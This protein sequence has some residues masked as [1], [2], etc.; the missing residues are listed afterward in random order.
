MTTRAESHVKNMTKGKMRG[1]G[2]KETTM[3]TG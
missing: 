2:R 1:R 3:V